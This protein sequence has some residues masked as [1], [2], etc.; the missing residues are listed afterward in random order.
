MIEWKMWFEN[1]KIAIEGGVKQ[2]VVVGAKKILSIQ[3]SDRD[4]QT[5]A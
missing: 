3:F 1:G 2:S 5:V 4:S